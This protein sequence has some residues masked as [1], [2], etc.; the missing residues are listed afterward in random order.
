MLAATLRVTPF[1]SNTENHG[2][3]PERDDAVTQVE[4]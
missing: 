1:G 2:R 3:S 4:A